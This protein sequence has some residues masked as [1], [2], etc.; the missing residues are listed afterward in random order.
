LTVKLS[1][2]YSAVVLALAICVAVLRIPA[3]DASCRMIEYVSE[4]FKGVLFVVTARRGQIALQGKGK[5]VNWGNSVERATGAPLHKYVGI[6]Q[7]ILGWHRVLH[8][9]FKENV[10]FILSVG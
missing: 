10:A 3:K 7:L 1:V 2:A 4:L 6:L 9:V 8:A 5:C